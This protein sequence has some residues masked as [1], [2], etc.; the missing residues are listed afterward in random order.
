MGRYVMTLSYLYHLLAYFSQRPKAVLENA[1]LITSIDIDV[2]SRKL[3]ILNNGKNDRN[4]SPNR[5]EYA[6]GKI[7]ETCL[8]VLVEKFEE[9][10][11]PATFAIR[12]QVVEV[13]DT[14][15]KI[16][17]KSKVK[18]DI[19]AHGYYHREFTNLSRN[20]AENELNMISVGLK[21]FGVNPRSF[22]FPKNKV[23][24]LDLLEKHGYKCYRGY[25]NF[26]NDCMYIEK[27]GRLYNIHPSLYL[28]EGANLLLLKKILNISISRKLPLH[29]WFHLW[30]FGETKEAIQ[31]NIKNVF[32]PFF[33]YAKRKERGN[34][35]SFETMFSAALKF[36]SSL[37]N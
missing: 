14:V 24:Y 37:Q 2:G 33:S 4:N 36:E 32:S 17:L 31:K 11:V 8:P 15:L 18:H 21:K 26:L 6:I 19:G 12:G 35:V 27:Q 1:M 34:L 25:G 23:A 13:D 5:S 20:E 10:E 29:L 3:G 16:L 30:N 9:F 28:A 22:V 7:E